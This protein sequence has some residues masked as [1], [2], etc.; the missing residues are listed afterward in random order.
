MSSVKIFRSTSLVS[1]LMIVVVGLIFCS[2]CSHYFGKSPDH[3]AEEYRTERVTNTKT[4]RQQQPQNEIEHTVVTDDEGLTIE[5]RRIQECRVRE[6]D[7]V[8]HFEVQDIDK[9]WP[10]LDMAGGGAALL[11]SPVVYATADESPL[12]FGTLFA[13][14]G[15]AALGYGLF[16]WRRFPEETPILTEDVERE[17]QPYSCDNLPL[18]NTAITATLGEQ[19]LIESQTDSQGHISIQWD[20]VEEVYITSTEENLDLHF[21]LKPDFLASRYTV[22]ESIP[23]AK[24]AEFEKQRENYL[25]TRV[26]EDNDIDSAFALQREYPTSDHSDDALELITRSAVESDDVEL[27]RDAL[28]VIEAESDNFETVHD[29][30][31]EILLESDDVE[32]LRDGLL[33]IEAEGDNFE[34]VHDHLVEILLERDESELFRRY[35]DRMARIF[36][37]EDKA[38]PYAEDIIQRYAQLWAEKEFE[39]YVASYEEDGS[40]SSELSSPPQTIPGLAHIYAEGN[41]RSMTQDY[42]LARARE[43]QQEA[44][45]DPRTAF[46]ARADGASVPSD[47]VVHYTLAMRFSEGRGDGEPIQREREEFVNDFRQRQRNSWPSRIQSALNQCRDGRGTVRDFRRRIRQLKQQGRIEELEDYMESMGEQVDAAAD[48][49]HDGIQ[50]LDNIMEEMTQEGISYRL[51]DSRD[52]RTF[53]W[54]DEPESQSRVMDVR[55]QAQRAC[56]D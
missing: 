40:G 35:F 16:F 32:L 12:L 49:W 25:W 5:F 3:G 20:N 33:I 42:H 48:R 15:A 27:I 39:S 10:A 53:K 19:L 8:E 11:A 37:E 56:G 13:V 36:D 44:F 1:A 9:K 54:D 2:G 50:Q 4:E 17:W 47:T 45:N 41:L 6:I 46:R 21:S 55:Q 23:D 24:F 51:P 30:L 7:E 28:L 22:S 31:V 38:P 18:R 29:H 14:G 52:F 43:L 34:T 26:T